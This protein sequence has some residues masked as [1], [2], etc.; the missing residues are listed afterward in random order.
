MTRITINKIGINH[1]FINKHLLADQ[2]KALLVFLHEGLGS[3]AQWKD[4]PELLAHKLNL[5]ALLYDRYG[6]GKSDALREQREASYLHTEADFLKD[7]IQELGIQN[8]LILI[9]HSDGGTISLLH[10]AKKE[11]QIKAVVCM[12]AHL[13]NEE[14]TLEGIREAVELYEDFDLKYM[15]EKFHGDKTDSTF[16]GWANTWLS[17]DF[18][19]WDIQKD[20]QEIDCPVLAIQGDRD[21]YGTEK[22]LL[23]IKEN[24]GQKASGFLVPKCGHIPHLQRKEDVL[25]RICEFVL[26]L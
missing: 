5:P 14:I 21:Q 18:K 12:A 17:E 13:F 26:S 7:F 15:L 4:F 6:Y 1:Q 2:N 10:A 19:S 11:T 22:Q 9:G 8:P 3:I 25:I 20:I 24:I 16:Y 23:S